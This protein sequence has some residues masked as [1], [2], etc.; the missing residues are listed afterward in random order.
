MTS[1]DLPAGW[2]VKSGF[3]KRAK[4]CEVSRRL[5]LERKH[6]RSKARLHPSGHRHRS[7][8]LPQ[9]R[10]CGL[11]R[12]MARPPAVLKP[13]WIRSALGQM[14]RRRL[15]KPRS[16]CRKVK[17]KC[18]LRRRALRHRKHRQRL[19]QCLRPRLS[20]PARLFQTISA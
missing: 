8:S 4:S 10:R 3:G 1:S 6:H 19:N 17:L 15:I 13:G 11:K 12:R 5:R 7:P 20:L 2:S 16:R 9:R 18:S 14:A